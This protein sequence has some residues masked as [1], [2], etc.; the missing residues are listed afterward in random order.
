MGSYLFYSVPEESTLWEWEQTAKQRT[1]PLIGGAPEL[2]Y[3]IFIHDLAYQLQELDFD[4]DEI[5]E[6]TQYFAQ[7]Y[8][9]MYHNHFADD[10]DWGK[11]QFPSPDFEQ[12]A[13]WLGRLMVCQN[14]P[15]A[16][17]HLFPSFY[18]TV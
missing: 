5:L 3:S 7:T 11:C 17:Q 8:C 18:I 10:S 15:Q 9:T 12:Y 16:F 13:D 14:H 4:E 1:P 2:D 6:F